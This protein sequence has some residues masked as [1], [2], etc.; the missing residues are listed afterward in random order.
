MLL[1]NQSSVKTEI[2]LTYAVPV[3]SLSRGLLIKQCLDWTRCNIQLS[4][5]YVL[6]AE[7]TQNESV[8][9]KLCLACVL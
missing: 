6:F 3:T 1:H 5:F 4:V 7:T 2:A 9:E 8:M